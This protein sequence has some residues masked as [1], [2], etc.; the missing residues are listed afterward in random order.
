MDIAALERM[1]QEDI[2]AART[3]LLLFANAGSPI[4]GQVD[5]LNRLQEICKA[6]DI[7]LHVEGFSL[8]SLALVSVP[9]LVRYNNNLNPKF[10][11]YSFLI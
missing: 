4:N 5:T 7:W 3:P 9:N 1:I 10:T 6:N 2:A 11:N 8:A